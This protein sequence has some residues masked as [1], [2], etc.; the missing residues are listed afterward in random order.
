MTGDT[1]FGYFFE[2]HLKRAADMLGRTYDRYLSEGLTYQGH[3][4]CLRFRVAIY[5]SYTYKNPSE[6]RDNALRY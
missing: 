5:S 1:I 2:S 4:S 3:P 6:A